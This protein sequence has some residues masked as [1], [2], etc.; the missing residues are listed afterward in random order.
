MKKWA[1]ELNREFSKEEVQMASKYMKKCP[2]SLAVKEIHSKTTLR[3]HLTPVRMAM[4]K[5]KNNNKCWQGCGET[6]S[7]MHYW[8][9]CK[10][11]QPLWKAVW[12][13]LKK[14]KIELLYDPVISILG[15]YPKEH[16][17][18]YNRDTYITM[19]ITALFTIAKLWKQPIFS[20]TDEWIKKMWYICI[21]TQP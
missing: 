2:T 3:F 4:F 13:V 14:L 5:S 9:E 16:T 1:H 12:R 7:F 17:S 8:W 15:I 21:C 20:T 18:G 10:L 6:G 19:F 11:V